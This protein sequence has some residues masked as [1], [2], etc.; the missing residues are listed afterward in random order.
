MSGVCGKLVIGLLGCGTVGGGVVEVLR[1]RFPSICIKKICVQD[2]NKTR[3]GVTVPSGCQ[4]VNSVRSVIDDEEINCIVEVMGGT[5]EAKVAMLDCLRAG[6]HVVTANKAAI[7]LHLDEFKRLLEEKRHCTAFMYEAAVCGGIPIISVV[8]RALS[9]DHIT[10]VVGIMNGTTNYMLTKM[11]KEG[12]SYE[13]VL[14]EAQQKGYA[15]ADPAADVDG[16]DARSKLCILTK[17][18]FGLTVNEQDVFCEGIQRIANVDFEY[19]KMINHTIKLLSIS[20]LCQ[21]AGGGA[22]VYMSVSPV[23]VPVDTPLGRIEGVTNVVELMSK[24]LGSSIYVGPGA[25]RYATAN[26]V[27]ADILEIQSRIDAKGGP[28][29]FPPAFPPKQTAQRLERDF[30]TDFFIRFVVSDQCGVVHKIAGLFEKH[31]ISIFSLLQTPITD[32]TRVPFVIVTDSCKLS[33]VSALCN[34]IEGNRKTEMTFVKERPM[35][36]RY[37]K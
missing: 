21:Q 36:I 17:L 33:Q 2:V 9:C 26:S 23:M 15:E 5:G 13:D 4:L 11:E 32:P 22:V 27:V 16:Y 12:I 3:P 29:I 24:N 19:A 35:F 7:A 6:K 18:A 34:E 20:E 8:Q 31:K 25:G 14:A 28:V 1:E 10:K 30:T 37:L